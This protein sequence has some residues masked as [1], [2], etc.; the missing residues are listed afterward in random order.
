MTK[1]GQLFELI[2]S[3]KKEEKRHFRLYSKKYAKASDYLKLFDAI[4]T[5]KRYDE[6]VLRAQ[7]DGIHSLKRLSVAKDYL[8]S[9][10]LRSLRDMEPITPEAKVLKLIED[11]S[12][13]LDRRL[14]GAAKKRI[15]KALEL[16]SMHDLTGALFMLAELDG[17]L[18]DSSREQLFENERAL[19]T[20]TNQIFELGTFAESLRVFSEEK[21]STRTEE[22]ANRLSQILSKCHYTNP[23]ELLTFSAKLRYHFGWFKYNEITGDAQG[24]IQNL[25]SIVDLYDHHPQH[26]STQQLAY[27]TIVLNLSARELEAGKRSAIPRYIE[28]VS[29]LQTNGQIKPYCE[30]MLFRFAMQEALAD[31]NWNRI[32]ELH[33]A[34]S[35]LL[36]RNDAEAHSFGKDIRI[37]LHLLFAR[38]YFLRQRFEVTLAEISRILQLPSLA[39]SG[40]ENNVRVLLIVTHYEL[41]NFT[42]LPYLIR[43]TY[44]ALL[45]RKRLFGF[46]AC[47]LN[48]IGSLAHL[49]KE[50][51]I[52]PSFKQLLAEIKMLSAHPIDREFPWREFYI[53]W[54]EKKISGQP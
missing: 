50:K 18:P 26:I 36:V 2:H 8:Y 24:V 7:L 15:R 49:M 6:P 39:G 29:T 42:Y 17:L 5:M 28:R 25:R 13:L 48:Y 38:A 43:S 52:I 14:F 19:L 10:I 54:L 9:L 41:G 35:D 3:L 20:Q 51:D 47:I 4:A 21:G 46:E 53:D 33:D 1:S 12:A 23:D 45:R 30:L 37:D 16:A 11:V 44:R 31:Y 40:Q 32:D 22:D 34:L 27:V